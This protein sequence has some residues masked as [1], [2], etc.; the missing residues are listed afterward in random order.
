MN[1]SSGS[2]SSY[3]LEISQTLLTESEI[4]HRITT[5]AAEISHDYHGKELHIISILK[6]GTV[7]IADLVRKLTIP[8]TMDFIA[9]SS[10]GGVSAATGVVRIVKDLDDS[11]VGREVLIVED[12]IDT[13]LTLNYLLRTLKPRGAESINICTL[14]DR[15]FRRIVNIPL[16]Y[17]GFDIPDH[18][19]VG[20]GLDYH[21]YYRNLPYI[22]IIEAGDVTWEVV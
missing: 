15:S 22:G 20:Y 14:L 6:G 5:L 4:S 8:V 11:V 7:F 9:I 19:V 1:E 13:G 17:V 2:A 18:Y 3:P 16:K 10:Y 21:G 12:I